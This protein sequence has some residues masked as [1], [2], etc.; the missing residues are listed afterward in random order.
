MERLCDGQ[1]N[2][3]GERG[4][5]SYHCAA[6]GDWKLTCNDTD[7]YHQQCRWK[8]AVSMYLDSFVLA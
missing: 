1:V 7:S 6:S 4:D 2:P 8:S 3:S 5:S